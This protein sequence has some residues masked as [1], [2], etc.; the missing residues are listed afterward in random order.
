MNAAEFLRKRG[1]I[2]RQVQASRKHSWGIRA[3]QA[4]VAEAG[5]VAVVTGQTVTGYRMPS[6]QV[7]CTKKRFPDQAAALDAMDQISRT[8][9]THEKPKRAYPCPH[10]KGWHLATI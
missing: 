1:I 2:A 10:C 3:M 7:A 6:G 4:L 5:A 9:G 8:Q